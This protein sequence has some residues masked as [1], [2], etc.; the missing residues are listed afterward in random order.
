MSLDVVNYARARNE[1]TH[2]RRLEYRRRLARIEEEAGQPAKAATLIEQ[3]TQ[4]TIAQG[5]LL[6]VGPQMA[7]LTGA[8]MR[9]TKDI[10]VLE[11][12]QKLAD[13]EHQLFKLPKVK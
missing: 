12:L 3:S 9:L 4:E 11:H 7:F 1:H 13:A 2:S 10:G 6:K 8:L 5:G